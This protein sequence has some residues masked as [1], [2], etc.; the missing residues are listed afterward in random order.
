MESGLCDQACK[1]MHLLE[2]IRKKE[3]RVNVPRVK[4]KPH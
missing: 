4:N 3:S 2:R 1:Q